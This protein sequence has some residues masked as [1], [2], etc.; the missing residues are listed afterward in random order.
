VILLE[1]GPLCQPVLF[2]KPHVQIVAWQPEQVEAALQQAAQAQA[3]GYWLAGY[4]SYELGYVL[5][6]RLR[7]LLPP[8]DPAWPVP[9]LALEVHSAP[10]CAKDILLQWDAAT[11]PSD[12]PDLTPW[13]PDWTAAQYRVAFDTLRHW[14]AQGDCYQANLTFA[15]RA[16]STTPAQQLYAFLRQRQ[17]VP[18]GALVDIGQGP[19]LLS[20]SPELFFRCDAHGKIEAGPMKGTMP[21]HSDPAQDAAIAKAL[22]QSSK[23][24]AENI[25]IVDLLRN[26]IGRLCEIG[27]VQVPQL[28]E[29]QSYA[30]VHQMVSRVVGQLRPEV[31]LKEMFRA[32]FPCGSVTGAPKIRAMEI[33]RTLEPHPRGAY[34]GSIGWAAPDGSAE[35][36]VAIRTLSLFEGGEVVLNVGSGVVFDSTADQEYEEALWKARFAQA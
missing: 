8:S 11:K 26:D 31:G 34:C 27:S 19:V 32:L 7:H 12:P 33:I 22:Q 6:P 4:A 16:H 18:F 13:L 3:A 24:R 2:A 14:I 1:R 20:R 5:E 25:M 9:L 10:V 29:V 21:R 17:A 35:W 28:F 15:L 30:T 36:S 23:N